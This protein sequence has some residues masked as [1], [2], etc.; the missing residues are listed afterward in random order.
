MNSPDHRAQILDPGYTQMGVGTAVGKDGTLWVAE[1]FRTPSGAPAPTAGGS[2]GGP[3]ATSG[4]GSGGATTTTP[5]APAPSASAP[6]PSAKQILRRNLREA[7]E[8][9]HD[10]TRARQS[11]DPIVGAL[12]FTTVMETITG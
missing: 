3:S 6:Q 8:K 1:V 10:R 4:G 5:T 7:R 9:I 2:G 11:N 12:D